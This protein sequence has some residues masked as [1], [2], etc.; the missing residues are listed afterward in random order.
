MNFALAAIADTFASDA[1]VV[2]LSQASDTKIYQQAYEGDEPG[3]N[4]QADRIP[5]LLI[6]L[7][8]A[9]YDREGDQS[10]KACA[11]S[12]DDVIGD[13]IDHS[14]NFLHLL[15]EGLLAVLGPEE[16]Q[17]HEGE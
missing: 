10:E 4:N 14:A 15:L 9:L 5:V 1:G 16:A 3:R 12:A 11:E 2:F 6:V 13:K 17:K 7:H 8:K